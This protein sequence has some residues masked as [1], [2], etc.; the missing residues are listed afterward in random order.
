MSSAPSKSSTWSGSWSW[1]AMARSRS[2]RRST[3]RPTSRWSSSTSGASGGRAPALRRLSLEDAQGEYYM[4]DA[5]A[6]LRQAGHKVVAMEAPGVAEA[7]GV[8]DQVQLAEAE[9]ALRARINGHWMR[10][11]VRMTDPA[12]T[13]IDATVALGRE[14][15]LLPGVVLEGATTVGAGSVIGPDT[16]L[17]DTT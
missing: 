12:R 15:E 17:V 5:I 7:M 8:N 11:G 6:V 14:V 1:G 10:E 2:S 16:R 3:A 13:Y 4:T 9:E